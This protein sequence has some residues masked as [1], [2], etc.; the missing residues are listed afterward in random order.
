MAGYLCQLPGRTQILLITAST[1]I[2]IN[3]R[4]L[5]MIFLA[6]NIWSGVPE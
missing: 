5:T 1:A 2:Q 6:L 3:Y 4:Y